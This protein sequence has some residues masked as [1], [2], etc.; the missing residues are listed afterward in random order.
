MG[1]CS[2]PWV[3]RGTPGGSFIHGGVVLALA[4]VEGL[5]VE[6]LAGFAA[7]AAEAELVAVPDAGVFAGF[8][9]LGVVWAL[10]AAASAANKIRAECFMAEEI[11]E[12]FCS[13]TEFISRRREPDLL[14]DN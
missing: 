10:A 14:S 8:G 7:G 2:G 6:T 1:V 13:N 11:S 12:S 5:A 3:V 4:A 9:V